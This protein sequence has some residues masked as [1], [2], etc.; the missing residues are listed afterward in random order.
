[1]DYSEARIAKAEAHLELKELQ[2]ALEMLQ[3]LLQEIIQLEKG[4]CGPSILAFL[5][6]A[7]FELGNYHEAIFAGN[8][9]IE[10]SRQRTG[11]HKYVALAQKELR[12][13]QPH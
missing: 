1:M 7:Q 2:T 12:D 5:M 10:W 11:V 4:Q 3:K 6:R 13:I 9:G 8:R